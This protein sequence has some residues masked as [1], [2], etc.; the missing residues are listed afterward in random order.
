MNRRKLL[1]TAAGALL[2]S[3]ALAQDAK[4][5]RDEPF[6]FPFLG[7]LHFDQLSHHD[8][9][10]LAK[11][12]PGDVRQV[13]DYSR[14]TREVTPKLFPEVKEQ[15]GASKAKV[16]FTLQIGDLVEGLC[17]TPEL[18]R[19]QCE[20]AITFVRAAQ[21][22]VPVVMTKGNHD[23]TGPGSVE[24]YG[25]VLLPAAT[26]M[27]P[28]KQSSY[29]VRAGNSLFLF[30]DAYQP[31]SLAWLEETLAKRSSRH[32]F[33]VIHPPV[34]P[35]NARSTW[36]VYSR[37]NQAAQRAKLLS[38]LGKHRAIV[39]SGHLHKYSCVVRRT[40]EGSFVQL[41][42]SSI[43]SRPDLQPRQA[44]SGLEQFG[45]DL[46]ALEPKF[47]EKSLDARRESLTAEKPFIR[48]WD[49]S[50]TA[51]YALV[52]VSG[53]RVSAR[54]FNGIGKRHWKSVDLTALRD[55]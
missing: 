50:D 35:Y 52:D 48:H 20:D 30:Y 6:S 53:D 28:A 10:W 7:D 18:A 11:E 1:G 43:I 41:S 24:A 49:Y 55:A 51:G 29:S 4:T 44:M 16:P 37:P 12:H 40:E 39:L 23:I 45:P 8:M 21:L 13:E 9:D 17:G 34:V 31:Q 26:G 5:D 33:L 15:I 19:K 46:V 25:Q 14:I 38:L 3:A 54:I 47:D 2:G 32:L 42:V 36:H 27:E 22:G